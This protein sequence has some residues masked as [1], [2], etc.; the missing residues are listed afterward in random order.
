MLA[1]QFEDSW[2]AV[3]RSVPS[4]RRAV[5]EHLRSQ[6]TADPPLN[7]ICLAVTEAVSNAVRHA[8]R[9]QEPGSVRVRVDV[10]ADVIAV[11]VEDDGS[12]IAPRVDSPGLG[13]GLPL[14]AALTERFEVHTGEEGGTQLWLWFPAQLTG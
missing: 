14:I 10:G 7:D 11:R 8:Y 5:R 1:E 2:D 9:E 13:L 6:R 3:P 4:A 12:G